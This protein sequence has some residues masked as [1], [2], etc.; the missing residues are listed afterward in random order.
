MIKQIRPE[1][2]SI[3]N[4]FKS[5]NTENSKALISVKNAFESQSFLQLKN[6]YCDP[7]RCLECAVGNVLLKG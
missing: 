5:L 3:I 4:K 2:N 1:Q 7:Q 6:N